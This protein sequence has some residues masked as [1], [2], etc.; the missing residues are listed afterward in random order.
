MGHTGRNNRTTQ[1]FS[2]G[3]KWDDNSYALHR[4]VRPRKSQSQSFSNINTEYSMYERLFHETR[5][6][7][8]ME[9]ILMFFST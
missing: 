2:E 7:C 1:R 4:P 3:T 5:W 9:L 8:I 6:V